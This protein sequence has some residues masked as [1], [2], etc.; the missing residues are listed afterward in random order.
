MMWGNLT[1]INSAQ[2]DNILIGTL[3]GPD[4]TISTQLANQDLTFSPNGLG[5]CIS[6]QTF[7][8]E[9]MLRLNQN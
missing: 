7:L 2:I 1:G 4:A 5:F 3:P 6:K 9:E 8:L